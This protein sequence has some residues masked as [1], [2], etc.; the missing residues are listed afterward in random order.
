MGT[1]RVGESLQ[2]SGL[3]EGLSRL[4]GCLW[5]YSIS[6]LSI[7]LFNFLSGFAKVAVTVGLPRLEV[8][9]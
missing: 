2:T 6:S 1:G 9:Q 4:V 7:H 3:V 8:W 5:R